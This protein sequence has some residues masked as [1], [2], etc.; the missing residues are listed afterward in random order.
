MPWNQTTRWSRTMTSV[1]SPTRPVW[2]R[3][4]DELPHGVVDMDRW[5]E[6]YLSYI[7]SPQSQVGVWLHLAH[8]PGDGDL[9]TLWDEVISIALPG[10]RTL[11]ARGF[12]EGSVE[13]GDGDGRGQVRISGLSFRCN[14]P[15]VSWTKK[16]RGAARLVSGDELRA[17]PITDGVYVPVSLDLECTMISPPFD[18]GSGDLDQSFAKA[19]Y[20]QQQRATGR[21]VLPGESYELE[22]SGLRDHSWGPRDWTKM[23][24]TTWI[25]GQFPES[26]RTFMIVY[27]GTHPDY[28]TSFCLAAV[29]DGE[30]VQYAT[31]EGV[32]EATNLLEAQRDAEFAIVMKDGTSVPG[33]A[34]V[35]A[36]MRMTL[37]GDTQFAGGTS[38]RDGDPY[39]SHDYVPA[40]AEIEWDGEVGLGYIERTVR[41][42]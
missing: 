41:L 3:D 28:P 8:V 35:L 19:H 42:Q 24:A 16:F 37:I 7:W 12:S 4:A 32:P 22:G 10:D 25:H 27:V 33:R 1:V 9:P 14:E 6:N 23:A 38:H 18:Y 5:V 2:L 29:S 15:F 40:F 39:P 26:G 11:F 30:S 31:A 36:P 13:H 34:K 21:L 17:G 20:D